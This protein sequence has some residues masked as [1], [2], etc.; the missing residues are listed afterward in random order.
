MILHVAGVH[1]FD[2]SGPARLKAWLT[3]LSYEQKTPPAFVAVEYEE[4][5]F[6]QIRR[7]RPQFRQLLQREWPGAPPDLL[8]VLERSL[9]YE[10]DTHLHVFPTVETFWLQHGMAEAVPTYAQGR[11][12]LY[13]SYLGEDPLPADTTAALTLLR[14]RAWQRNDPPTRGNERDARWAS[15]L[16]DRL[17]KG[18]GERAIVVVGANHAS[19]YPGYLVPLLRERGG[20]CD[21]VFLTPG[22]PVQTWPI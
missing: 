18:D 16:W 5:T 19:G 1:H 20:H 12:L 6:E 3:G 13:Q 11:L 7:Q 10:A 14:A 21:V 22:G 2:P 15:L 9:A 17:R 4:S 8:E